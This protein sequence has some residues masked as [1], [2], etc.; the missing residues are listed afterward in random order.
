MLW[1]QSFTLGAILIWV[2]TIS[3]RWSFGSLYSRG[4]YYQ[5]GVII[6]RL[7][8]ARGDAIIPMR[9]DEL[10]PYGAGCGVLYFLVW[11]L[12][13]ATVMYVSNPGHLQVM[14]LIKPEIVSFG[15][16]KAIIKY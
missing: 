4:C 15:Q 8:Y 14:S 6:Q 13:C 7:R 9:T 11:D 5:G 1:L 16:K 10:A 12:S 2:V 3:A